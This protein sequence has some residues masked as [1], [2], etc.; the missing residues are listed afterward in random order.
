MYFEP[1]YWVGTKLVA[2]FG[3]SSL[4]V[5]AVEMVSWELDER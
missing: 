3:L 1:A 2:G 4:M 5:E